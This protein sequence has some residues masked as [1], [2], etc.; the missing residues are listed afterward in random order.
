MAASCS[1][2]FNTLLNLAADKSGFIK[3]IAKYSADMTLKERM[4]LLDFIHENSALTSAKDKYVFG[5]AELERVSSAAAE[6]YA[7]K[8]GDTDRLELTDTLIQMDTGTQLH[9]AAAIIGKAYYEYLKNGSKGTFY[10]P[11]NEVHSRVNKMGNIK[12][13]KEDVEAMGNLAKVFVDLVF[14]TQKQID[15]TVMPEMRFEWRVMNPVKDIGGTGDIFAFYSDGTASYF[16][17]KTFEPPAKSKTWDKDSKAMNV[18][19]PLSYQGYRREKWETTI[20]EYV[21]ILKKVLK[22]KGIRH[23]LAI[24]VATYFNRTD[25]YKGAFERGDKLKMERLQAEGRTRKRELAS[26]QSVMDTTD[27]VPALVLPVSLA[28][29]PDMTVFISERFKQLNEY[30]RVMSTMRSGPEKDK[31]K[32]RIES[33][34]IMIDKVILLDDVTTIIHYV[35]NLAQEAKDLIAAI[36]KDSQVAVNRWEDVRALKT[37]LDYYSDLNSLTASY[38][39]AQAEKA[40]TKEEVKQVN[41]ATKLLGDV[42]RTIGIL[43]SSLN[44]INIEQMRTRN[45]IDESITEEEL[46]HKQIMFEEDE[47]LQRYFKGAGQSNNPFFTKMKEKHAKIELEIRKELEAFMKQSEKHF[48]ILEEFKKSKGWSEAAFIEFMINPKTGNLVNKFKPEMFTE[49]NKAKSSGNVR[50]FIDNYTVRDNYQASY[51][52]R[53]QVQKE[54]LAL[55]FDRSKPE[56]LEKYN[57]VLNGWIEENALYINNHIN[58]KAWIKDYN[59]KAFLKR[60]ES[61][62]SKFYSEKYKFMIANPKLKQWYDFWTESMYKASERLGHDADVKSNLVPWIRKEF[63][64]LAISRK[65][66]MAGDFLDSLTMGYDGALERYDEFGKLIKSVPILFTQPFKKN[67]EYDVDAKSMDLQKSLLMFMKMVL[68][69]EK[70][71][72]HEVEI[73]AMRDLLSDYGA[74]YQRTAT[75]RVIT[76]PDGTV[77]AKR[78]NIE[79]ALK[80]YDAYVDFYWYGNRLQSTDKTTEFLGREVS[81]NRTLMVAKNLFGKKVLAWSIHAPL[82]NLIVGKMGSMVTARK[83]LLFNTSTYNK[84]LMIQAKS[85]LGSF[86]QS[87]SDTKKYKAFIAY[88]DPFNEDSQS[89]KIQNMSSSKLDKYLGNRSQFAFFH[90]SDEAVIDTL[91]LSIAMHYRVS[92]GVLRHPDNAKAGSKTL[93]E[94]FKQTENKGEVTMSLEGLTPE[95]VDNIWIAYRNIVREAQR[96]ITGSISD[97]E[98]SLAS[99]NVF[100]NMA[101]Q[102]RSWLPNVAH[103]MFKGLKYDKTYDAVDIGR[104]TALADTFKGF[105]SNTGLAQHA[106]SIIGTIVQLFAEVSFV[107]RYLYPEKWGGLWNKERAEIVFNEWAANH[108]KLAKNVTL[109][110]Y[111]QARKRQLIALISQLRMLLLMT[112]VYMV[113]QA[114]W[115]DDDEKDFRSTFLTRHGFRVLNRVYTEFASMFNPAELHRLL[116]GGPIPTWGLLVSLTKLFSNGLDEIKDSI[117]GE[118]S[119]RDTTPFFYYTMDFIPLVDRIRKILELTEADYRSNR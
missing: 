79:Q 111:M 73:M 10:P 80:D 41:D 104:M 13:K 21:D 105:K 36:K 1:L 52:R 16:D 49:V 12:I 43:S 29:N 42:S 46:L 107:G 119:K 74:T 85:K 33:L 48:N 34:Q 93:Y 103:E 108:P 6:V 18:T 35:N 102:F 92:D 112:M 20:P 38:L 116:S 24:P 89:I 56:E 68:N 28:N 23:A 84:A 15:P 82:A 69:Y 27:L 78:S 3:E 59:I 8:G 98:I 17:Y 55:R 32:A 26:I 25:E 70:K 96:G 88:F 60:K 77:K 64:E 44:V 39:E 50:F 62:E 63:I 67:G 114:D 22:V 65:G 83:G 97:E 51:D 61:F 31:M 91:A 58:P 86:M 4:E 2:K 47:F 14:E 106:T 94:L 71:T 75:G 9:D 87:D 57:N 81:M 7:K 72:K 115:D 101:M 76:N 54:K 110:Q 40:T 5:K 90:W 95:Q 118:N 53:L 113:A 37:E 66:N 109:E 45:L 11:I 99:T 30:K 100:A 19:E 117:V